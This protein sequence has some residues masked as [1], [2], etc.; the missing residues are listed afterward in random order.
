MYT[1]LGRPN[2]PFCVDARDCLY[3]HDLTYNYIDVRDSPWLRT[4]CLKAGFTTVPLVFDPDG[5]FLGGYEG[6][7]KHLEERL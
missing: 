1:I 3:A 2:C 5:N 6:L 4:L 7:S